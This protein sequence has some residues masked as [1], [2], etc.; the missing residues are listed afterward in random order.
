MT[1]PSAAIAY[2][3]YQ[4]EALEREIFCLFKCTAQNILHA[5]PKERRF[6]TFKQSF[7][8]FFKV[9]NDCAFIFYLTMHKK[10]QTWTKKI[11]TK[12]SDT[13]PP[14]QLKKKK[15]YSSTT[16]C[17]NSRPVNVRLQNFFFIKTRSA[18]KDG[19]WHENQSFCVTWGNQCDKRYFQAWEFFYVRY[20]Y[21]VSQR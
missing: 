2:N 13:K 16:L 19:R 18:W 3:I 11:E 20:R 4:S 12:T 5:K 10:N 14:D 6:L 9:F 7:L 8:F 1:F 15:K 17:P 21:T